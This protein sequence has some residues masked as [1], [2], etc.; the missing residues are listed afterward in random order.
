MTKNE[1]KMRVAEN[2]SEYHSKYIFTSMSLGMGSESCNNCINFIK[3]KCAKELFDNIKH[4][5]SIN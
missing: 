4:N 2:C 1:L 5:I 3:G